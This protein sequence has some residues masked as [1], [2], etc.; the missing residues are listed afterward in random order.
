MMAGIIVLVTQNQGRYISDDSFLSTAATTST[1]S[2]STSRR[3]ATTSSFIDALESSHET[4][5]N[6]KA[7]FDDKI[8][9]VRNLRDNLETLH[10]TSNDIVQTR[11]TISLMLGF[12]KLLPTVG[13]FFS[14]SKVAVDSSKNP[15]ETLDNRIDHAY[16][17]LLKPVVD[18]MDDIDELVDT[19]EEKLSFAI[20]SVS[21]IHYISENQCVKS[22]ITTAIPLFTPVSEE[23]KK[24]ISSTMQLL[25][26]LEN[27]VNAII[28]AVDGSI[29]QNLVKTISDLSTNIKGLED[30]FNLFDPITDFINQEITIPFPSSRERKTTHW[31]CPTG[32]ER[33]ND[34]CAQHCKTG[35]SRHSFNECRTNCKHHGLEL[36]HDVL[37][38]YDKCTSPGVYKIASKKYKWWYCPVW[39]DPGRMCQDACPRDKP[40]R[41]G[42]LDDYCY[43][44]CRSGYKQKIRVHESFPNRYCYKPCPG[45]MKIGDNESTCKRQTYSRSKRNAYC[46][47]GYV[48][49]WG[50]ECRQ[51]CSSDET[52]TGNF[53]LKGGSLTLS[54]SDIGEQLQ[55]W[56]S[57]ALPILDLVEDFIDGFI[58]DAFQV[59][60]NLIPGDLPALPTLTLKP[61][62]TFSNQVDEAL[63]S[64][65]SFIDSSLPWAELKDLH[66]L[67][68]DIPNT[69]MENVEDALNIP[70]LSS[71]QDLI[72]STCTDLNCVSSSLGMDIN[73]TDLIEVSERLQ[74]L[75]ESKIDTFTS[76]IVDLIDGL[77]ECKSLQEVQ[78]RNVPG[79]DPNALTMIE[80]VGLSNCEVPVCTEFEIDIAV[81]KRVSI[82]LAALWQSL[83]A[84]LMQEFE[85]RGS[86]R[87]LQEEI[88]SFF[89]DGFQFTQPLPLAFDVGKI[90]KIPL[91]KKF[92]RSWLTYSED[93]KLTYSENQRLGV[94]KVTELH[95]DPVVSIV[96]TL[97]TPENLTG[98][99][100]G[101][102]GGVKV[103]FDE[104]EKDIQRE[105]D[106]AVNRFKLYYSEEEGDQK[107]SLMVIG[108]PKCSKCS[109]G[110][111]DLCAVMCLH[112]SKVKKYNECQSLSCYGDRADKIKKYY[113][114]LEKESRRVKNH[115]G[116]LAG[117]SGMIYESVKSMIKKQL[118]SFKKIFVNAILKLLPTKTVHAL[119]QIPGLAEWRTS[120]TDFVEPYQPLFRLGSPRMMIQETPVQ[121]VLEWW[122]TQ[123]KRRL[124]PQLLLDDERALKVQPAKSFDFIIVGNIDIGSV[125][126]LWIPSSATNSK[127]TINVALGRGERTKQSSDYAVSRYRSSRAVDGA[128]SGTGLDFTHTRQQTDPWWEYDF[129]SKNA[130]KISE[131]VV[132]N[133]RS[134]CE[135]RLKGFQ[136]LL[137]DQVKYKQTST[138]ESKTTIVFNPPMKAKNKV[139]IKIPGQNRILSLAE[140][141]IWGIYN[142]A[143]GKGKQTKQSSDYAR[144]P[145]SKAVDGAT[146][147]TGSDFTHTSLQTDPWWNLDLGKEHVISTIIVHNRKSCCGSRL[148]GFM[149]FLDYSWFPIYAHDTRTPLEQ[150]TTISFHDV[151]MKATNIR[152]VLPGNNKILSLAEVEVW[153]RPL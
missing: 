68:S 29:L 69:I 74:S 141:E 84:D 102:L 37:K 86:R 19:V 71:L 149:V 30:F 148:K 49:D 99:N 1:I 129:E 88:L 25:D 75:L 138:L 114:L 62:E 83:I 35:Y 57:E 111:V 28:S 147:G 90:L 124:Y 95:V 45:N 107:Q 59:V 16:K 18:K 54:L 113:A 85:H 110:K 126:S 76:L 115:L 13:S 73:L 6:I 48:R 55:I 87:R 44:S 82:Q 51:V 7:R 91:K 106:G 33:S 109:E 132:Y 64:L 63:D 67:I 8:T 70:F 153:G 92:D 151:P 120:A 20:S 26:D 116:I 36:I 108:H 105:K 117:V 72:P 77:G 42:H 145:S 78:L 146:S 40:H 14:A 122:N 47:S 133:R 56:K 4:L 130:T 50:N 144:F 9:P 11:S 61:F 31:R 65:N 79:L 10:D 34:K 80:T 112:A 81:L 53:C 96:I 123:A 143:L 24:A 127:T 52:E 3:A 22:L 142:V 5:S 100:I 41:G 121:F 27:K 38:W 93:P 135:N 43:G 66:G 152:I 17:R 125:S 39:N 137:D 89:L 118:K 101:V 136:V 58:E 32:Y 60:K 150:V 97:N 2:S 119:D 15:L 12:A 46:P 134:C 128:T 104:Y 94:L 131:I 23:V 21:G 139:S 140:V 98:I 103:S